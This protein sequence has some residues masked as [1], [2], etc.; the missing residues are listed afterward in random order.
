M[1]KTPSAQMMAAQPVRTQSMS[2][3]IQRVQVPNSPGERAIAL[4]FDAEMRL[5]PAAFHM[6]VGVV[7]VDDSHQRGQ[8]NHR[9]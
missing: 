6:P 7:L 4:G 2:C 1:G 9:I 8:L 5:L 3:V